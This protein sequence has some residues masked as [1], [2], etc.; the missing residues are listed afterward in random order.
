[1]DPE[2]KRRFS[3]QI[4]FPGIGERGQER[5]LAS[6]VALAGCGGLGSTIAACMARAGVGRLTIID[7]ESVDLSNLHRQ[8]LYD[9]E[10]VESGRN[11]A[12]TAA[13][14]LGRACP[15][16]RVQAVAETLCRDNV[17]E[18]L[19]G[20]HLVMDGLDNM[21]ARY[22]VNRW[23]VANNTP[24]IYGGVWGS[25]GMTMVILPGKG[26][27]LE[28]LFPETGAKD[29]E[30]PGRAVINTLPAHLAAIQSTEAQKLLIGSPELITDLQVVDLWT[31]QYQRIRINRQPGCPCC[32]GR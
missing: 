27:C 2:R 19:S 21:E 32:A 11:K 25:C 28:C 17:E 9:Q 15:E 14:K 20:R 18:L 16:T 4:E 3:R 7:P 12:M 8:L 1:M 10:D 26:P 13:Q 23:C 22:L 6:S 5:L 29:R 31:G 30:P 24:W